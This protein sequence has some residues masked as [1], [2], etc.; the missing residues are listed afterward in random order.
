MRGSRSKPIIV[1]DDVD[2]ATQV[3]DC[4]D[5]DGCNTNGAP[6]NTQ[7]TQEPDREASIASFDGMSLEWED[8]GW[9]HERDMP[10]SDQA[11]I[12]AGNDAPWVAYID[13]LNQKIEEQCVIVDGLCG[14]SQTHDSQQEKEIQDE[15]DRACLFIR[16]L[17]GNLAHAE[18]I[19]FTVRV[20][21]D[22]NT[23]RSANDLAGNP[24]SN[25]QVAHQVL[26]AS[27]TSLQ[28]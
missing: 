26:E 18:E 8:A 25:A 11:D 21:R 27:I 16:I 15:Y 20:T 13:A 23:R 17:R 19:L 22:F 24:L 2:G 9:N 6:P 28:L 5:D 14:E 3:I 10:T 7:T 12:H 1:D 4:D